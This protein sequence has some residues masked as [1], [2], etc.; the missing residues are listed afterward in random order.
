MMNES[1]RA[2]AADSLEHLLSQATALV[3]ALRDS[4]VSDELAYARIYML[5]T[6]IGY[7]VRDLGVGVPT[8]SAL[9]DA[10]SIMSNNV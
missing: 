10:I 9:R 4:E 6:R 8:T 3:V 2:I 1:K 7:I 5:R